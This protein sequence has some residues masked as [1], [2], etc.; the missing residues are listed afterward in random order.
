MKKLL[1]ALLLLIPALLPAQQFTHRYFHYDQIYTDPDNN[2]KIMAS[3]IDG[4]DNKA[5]FIGGGGFE[6]RTRGAWYA[7]YGNESSGTG[8]FTLFGGN[9]LGGDLIMYTGNN[10]RRLTIPYLADADDVDLVLGSAST[11]AP[12]FTI[13]G[14]T[15]DGDDDGVLVICSTGACGTARGP[16]LKLEGNEAASGGDVTLECGSSANSALTLSAPTGSSGILY[17]LGGNLRWTY[18][19]DGD[20][21]QDATNGGNIVFQK[22]KTGVIDST[23]GT[24]AT[25]SVLADATLIAANVTFVTDAD[26]TKGVKLPV[27]PIGGQRFVIYN[28]ANAVLKVWPGEATDNI[29]ANADGVNVA[30]A[31]YATLYCHASSAD[32]VWCGE[33]DNP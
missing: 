10:A 8:S 17:Y 14:Q 32:V 23:E 25:G 15:A 16:Y 20:L 27:A 18:E 28:T 4:A 21:A 22:D 9:V 2:F 5:I 1:L 13:R 6:D 12:I 33:L 31:A 11:T 3:T 26:A 30:V 7:A 24:A 29:N 19:L